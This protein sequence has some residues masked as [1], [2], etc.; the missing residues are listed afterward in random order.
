MIEL[1]PHHK[2]GLP[3][4]GPILPATG[5]LG[6]SDECRRLIPLEALGAL[7]TNPITARPRRGAKPPRAVKIT[8]GLL[9]HTGLRNPGLQAVI[10]RHRKRW[11]RSPVPVIAHVAGVNVDGAV[12]CVERLSE[13][14]CV[15]GVELGLPDSLTLENA[16]AVITATRDACSLPLIV[17][18]PLWQATDP[19]E[20]GLA[21]R[22]A[23][24]GGADALTV[25]APPRGTV[26]Q[27][28]RTIT[29]R[30][31]GPATFPQALWALR[32]VAD[33]IGDALPLVGCGGVHST[34]DA[35]ALL[36]SGAVAVQVD[37]HVWQDPAGMARL[38]R[39]VWRA[40]DGQ[41]NRR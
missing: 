37:G 33:L 15:A 23:D 38:A 12:T 32:R 36:D 30:L 10:R 18:L 39:E 31:Y 1:A 6:Y 11:A 26:R 40:K 41:S 16:L 22:V 7:V 28:G 35:L 14:E 3:L 9:M 2:R 19:S 25:A 8:G 29:G 24:C 20:R 21:A 5:V 17:K 4:K 27:Q 34:A 13:L